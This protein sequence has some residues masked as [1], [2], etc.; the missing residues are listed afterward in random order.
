MITEGINKRLRAKRILCRLN[1]QIPE[2]VNF[3]NIVQKK[4]LTDC[5]VLDSTDDNFLYMGSSSSMDFKFGEKSIANM[6]SMQEEDINVIT[7]YKTLPEEFIIKTH[8]NIDGFDPEMWKYRY[9]K[10]LSDEYMKMTIQTKLEHVKNKKRNELIRTKTT[11]ELFNDG[12]INEHGFGKV[13]AMK[14]HLKEV[15]DEKN[16]LPDLHGDFTHTFVHHVYDK[17]LKKP[18][19][20]GLYQT[21]QLL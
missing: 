17:E 15:E 10:Y 11:E 6:L 13:L 16:C 20:S 8:Q 21:G 9:G 14:Q 2:H 19:R 5:L 3:D 18:V 1:N 4:R 12:V 7:E